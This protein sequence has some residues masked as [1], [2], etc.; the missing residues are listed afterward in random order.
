MLS[1]PEGDIDKGAQAMWQ[2]LGPIRFDDIIQ[3]NFE[4]VDYEMK[5]GKSS[6]DENICG[7]IDTDMYGMSEYV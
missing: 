7:Q 1:K 2:K 3:N 4:P 5:F 6:N